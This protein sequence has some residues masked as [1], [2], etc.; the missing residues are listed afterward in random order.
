ML[1]VAAA[2]MEKNAT[3]FIAAQF[4]VV[5]SSLFFVAF[6]LVAGRRR[7]CCHWI[8]YGHHYKV[9][10]FIGCPGINYFQ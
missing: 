4:S 9:T 3:L 8:I 2:A 1:Q 7:L 10:H 6:N 5:A